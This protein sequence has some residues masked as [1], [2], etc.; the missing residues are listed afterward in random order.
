MQE[1][2]K[3]LVTTLSKHET[4]VSDLNKTIDSQEQQISLLK[5]K[6][7]YP[8]LMDDLKK[9]NS[10]LKEE[11]RKLDLLVKES[12]HKKVGEL[13]NKFEDKIN[14][15]LSFEEKGPTKD[16]A[17]EKLEQMEL[18]HKEDMNHLKGKLA[19]LEKKLNQSLHENV[20]LNAE[21]N[22]AIQQLDDNSFN[23]ESVIQDLQDKLETSTLDNTEDPALMVLR[24]DLQAE[25]QKSRVLSEEVFELRQRTTLDILPPDPVSP[26]PATST[27]PLPPPPPPLV[28]VTAPSPQGPSKPDLSPKP[29]SVKVLSDKLAEARNQAEVKE[30]A[31][32]Q[33]SDVISRLQTQI[34]N[35]E[36]DLSSQ[37]DTISTLQEQVKRGVLVSVTPIP[38]RNT[39]MER[40]LQESIQDKQHLEETISI[41]TEE[42]ELQIT[43]LN[44]RLQDLEHELDEALDQDPQNLVSQLQEERSKRR[45]SE[46]RVRELEGKLAEESLDDLQGNL[47]VAERMCEQL[48]ES[49]LFDDLMGGDSSAH[50]KQQLGN[51]DDMIR[52]LEKDNEGL[53]AEVEQLNSEFAEIS[54]EIADADCQYGQRIQNLQKQMK[55]DQEEHE[56]QV[57]SFREELEMLN[58]ELEEERNSDLLATLE[59]E[60]IDL[61][62]EC[63]ILTDR[64]AA[65]ILGK[66]STVDEKREVLA[67]MKDQFEKVQGRLKTELGMKKDKVDSLKED[68]WRKEQNFNRKIAAM[69]ESQQ[70]K[71]DQSKL[72]IEEHLLTSESLKSELQQMKKLNRRF[73]ENLDNKNLEFNEIVTKLL[74]L[75]NLIEI[76]QDNLLAKDEEIVSFNRQLDNLKAELELAQQRHN[77]LRDESIALDILESS[78]NEVSE[79]DRQQEAQIASLKLELEKS[80]F[81]KDRVLREKEL[82]SMKVGEQKEELKDL[83]KGVLAG[84]KS[85]KEVGKLR[86]DMEDLEMLVEDLKD[87]EEVLLEQIRGLEEEKEDLQS[88]VPDDGEAVDEL[89]KALV[90]KDKCIEEKNNEINSILSRQ[91]K[92]KQELVTKNIQLQN[93]YNDLMEKYVDLETE[94][95]CLLEDIDTNFKTQTDTAKD[96]EMQVKELKDAIGEKE[97]ALLRSEEMLN[98]TEANKLADSQSWFETR[99]QLET[100]VRICSLDRFCHFPDACSGRKNATAT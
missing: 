45:M 33:A 88:R 90:L 47:E 15:Q 49:E 39:E 48:E 52:E 5:K 20:L 82:L 78:L 64:L 24:E 68:I 3:V 46:V 32:Q 69:R 58:E 2:Q 56:N 73:E 89:K 28:T 91:D 38:E 79:H 31:F 1:L 77:I 72:K 4:L 34:Q 23:Y 19:I 7:F 93:K 11:V 44:S 61:K 18:L 84:E 43:A 53:R 99:K 75:E 67:E 95:S 63:K 80:Y 50:L 9:E 26:P 41:L 25:K 60:N 21:L 100:E 6:N 12:P 70:I 29:N 62:E 76:Q 22:E 16:E 83:K 92:T 55:I 51:K 85:D 37:H 8:K 14:Q 86:Q 94:N 42:H 35:L 96:L 81:D 13:K 10:R 65:D 57:E 30:Q 71:E 17:S 66:I 27:E 74:N 40:S 98:A 36:Q 87:E 97:E 59:D 54:N